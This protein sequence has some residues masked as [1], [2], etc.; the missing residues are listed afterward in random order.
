MVDAKMYF[1][2]TLGRCFQRIPCSAVKERFRGSRDGSGG[3]R[4]PPA[5]RDLVH[6]APF[7]PGLESR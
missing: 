3:F 1:F 7:Q 4:Q 2:L 5:E 6:S